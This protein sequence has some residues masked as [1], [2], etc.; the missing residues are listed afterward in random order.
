M[1]AVKRTLAVVIPAVC[2]VVA[3]AA[4]GSSGGASSGGASSGGASA[5][6]VAAP[7]VSTAALNAVLV[8]AYGSKV[9]TSTLDPVS[10]LA[11]ETAA[12]PVTAQE[13]AKLL[14]CYKALGT[15]DL[16]RK[17]ITVGIAEPNIKQSAVRQYW[18]ADY[19]LQAIQTPEIGKVIITDGH[20]DLQATLA[21]FSSLVSQHVAAIV[22][23]FDFADSMGG[24]GKQAEAAGIPVVA[25][26]QP[27]PNM[28]LGKGQWFLGLNTCDV[29][30]GTVQAA[31]K[32]AGTKTGTIGLYTGPPGN[33][34]AAVW[35]PC[36]Q[37]AVKAAG[38]MYTV[39]YT[40]WTPQGME[41]AASQLV[42]SGK[43]LDA[44]YSDLPIS[45]G[46]MN[47]LL[48]SGQPVPVTA[49][50]AY[51]VQQVQLCLSSPKF[52][53]V[54]GTQQGILMRAAITEAAM[55]ADHEKVPASITMQQSYLTPAELVKTVNLSELPPTGQFNS[56]LS[57]EL[58]TA[59]ANDN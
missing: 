28:T 41:Q 58:Q 34:F 51:S 25:V 1:F 55:L 53:C 45:T 10:L 27:I 12:Q 39:G 47:K 36:A 17:G 8:D 19:L 32:A 6:T 56:V 14:Q 54:M 50:G 21:N 59:L 35:M 48:D 11:A 18:V 13:Q 43:H 20:G 15:C 22:G 7:K 52:R 5:S 40:Q 23:D 46:F 9:A 29:G 42:S 2:T 30:S 26:D 44:I 31:I 24:V 37:K 33:A 49:G 57:P 16:G 3:L 38:W 4:C